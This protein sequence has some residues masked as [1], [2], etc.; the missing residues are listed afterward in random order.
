MSYKIENVTFANK[1]ADLDKVNLHAQP[2]KTTNIL[3]YNKNQMSFMKRVL[4]GQEKNRSGR[5]QVNN[6]DIINKKF[7]KNR[8]EFIRNDTW[9]ERVIP[10]KLV[11][12]LSLLFDPKFLRKA[13]I[14]TI[15]KKHDYLSFIN[16]KNDVTD[17]RLRRKIDS[18]ISHFIDTTNIAENKL[19][20]KF[21]SEIYKYDVSK[22]KQLYS[23]FPPQ[24]GV[25]AKEISRIE[26]MLE[27][28]Q[29]MLTFSQV[30]WDNI[31]A[32]NE[33]RDS[34]TCEYNAKKSSN[35]YVRKYW[36]KFSYTQTKYMIIK[37]LK[38]LNFNLSELR[39][40]IWR[41][42]K[43]HKQLTRQFNLE[44]KKFY[45]IEN[46]SKESQIEV[47][48]QH[49]K[50]KRVVLDQ[51]KEFE[52]QQKE[53]L[54]QLLPSE[55]YMIGKKITFLIHD[56]HKK[57]LSGN[58]KYGNQNEFLILKKHYK[59]EIHS[60]FSQALE[61]TEQHLEKLDM[62]FDWFI[63]QG[64]KISSLNIIYLKILKAINLQKKN[65]VFSNIL[66]YLSQKDFHDLMNTIQKIQKVYPDL[67]FI[68]LNNSLETIWDLQEPIYSVEK[69]ELK[70]MTGSEIFEI[71][72]NH[73]FSK[74]HNSSNVLNYRKVRQGIEVENKYWNITDWS[75]NDKGKIFVNLFKVNLEP[76]SDRDDELPI[77]LKIIK[78]NKYNDPRV[79]LGF[80]KFKHFIFFY[81][82]QGEYLE[83]KEVI[84]YINRESISKII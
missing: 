2:G 5:F 35:K 36:K 25:L 73:I 26:A 68:T 4:K 29:A 38:F 72:A 3:I 12:F 79:Y 59:K 16:S 44:L 23:K 60:T 10:A 22:I 70:K 32:L 41:N 77:V 13:R 63:K 46:I 66:D 52:E 71:N 15:D 84:V 9:I 51:R 56:Y 39:Y 6:I 18:V 19:L 82:E 53:I 76:S 57:L 28:S 74:V 34:C 62:K 47:A 8:I 48:E 50:W 1:V 37:Q 24:V 81:D 30:L 45:E 54:F 7:V 14:K 78:Q 55:G 80:N 58:V 33:L 64:F 27:K 61:W 43:L 67:A 17:M 49:L 21:N 65:I 42:K 11:L 69:N 83:N 75:L 31:F 20:N 40:S